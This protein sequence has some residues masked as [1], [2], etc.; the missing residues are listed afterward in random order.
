MTHWHTVSI[1][2]LNKIRPRL[3][4]HYERKNARRNGS[5]IAGGDRN[6]TDFEIAN[7]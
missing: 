3:V 2:E 5:V 6:M 4:E 7:A 1:D